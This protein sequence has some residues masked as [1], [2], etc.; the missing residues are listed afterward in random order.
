MILRA[1]RGRTYGTLLVDLRSH[2]TLDILPDRKA[3]TAAAQ[4]AGPIQKF[5]W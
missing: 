5:G 4:D 2:H 3:E 1:P